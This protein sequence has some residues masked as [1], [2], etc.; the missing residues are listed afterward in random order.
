M[1]RS[2]AELDR[3]RQELIQVPH[4]K[5]VVDAQLAHV[6]DEHRVVE[7]S[8]ITFRM[9]TGAEQDYHLQMLA[10]ARVEAANLR[11]EIAEFQ[12]AY[13]AIMYEVRTKSHIDQ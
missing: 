9:E 11:S 12:H 4:K 8:Q 7:A 5:R 3:L 6:T 1:L 10:R 13:M 2:G